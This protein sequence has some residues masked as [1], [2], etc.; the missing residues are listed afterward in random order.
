M[1]AQRRG[2]VHEALKGFSS[3]LKFDKGKPPGDAQK[4]AQLAFPKRVSRSSLILRKAGGRLPSTAR[5]F[6][7]GIATYSADDLKLLDDIEESLQDRG[8]DAVRIDVFDVV[9]CRQMSDFSR[10][11]P[12]IE[13]VY[14]TPVIGV[15]V[16]GKLIDQATGISDVS[17]TL[18][19]FNVLN[20]H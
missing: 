1:A 14:R 7:L 2:G 8:S 6:I 19:R 17:N 3:L 12:G 16:D 9:D 15:F 11:I 5:C 18:R 20:V 4:R 10:Y 13:R